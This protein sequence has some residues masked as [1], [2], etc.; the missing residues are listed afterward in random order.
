MASAKGS[1]RAD[2]DSGLV[3]VILASDWLIRHVF[4]ACT[5]RM[6]VQISREVSKS[7][8]NQ[9]LLSITGRCLWRYSWV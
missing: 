7:H 9:I 8:K 1:H 5:H 6:T 3:H 4:S 2:L